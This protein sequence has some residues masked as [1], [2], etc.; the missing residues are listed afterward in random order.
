MIEPLLLSVVIPTHNRRAALQRTLAALA[1]QSL[2]PADFEVVVVADGCCD[3]TEEMVSGL[4]AGICLNVVSQPASGPGAARNAGAAVARG[5]IV[6]FLDDD[7]EASPGL[8]AAHVRAHGRSSDRVVLGYLPPVLETQQGYIRSLLRLWWEN[9]FQTLRDPAHQFKYKNLLTGNVSLHADLFRRVGGFEPRLQ[10]HEDYELGL[11]LIEA[12]ATFVFEP[13][14]RGHHHEL[15]DVHRVLSRKYQEGRADVLL[16][17]LHP[18]LKPRLRL[19]HRTGSR[20][21]GALVRFIFASPRASG[22]FLR[23]LVALLAP[24]EAMGMRRTWY[25]LLNLLMLAYYWRGVAVEIGSRG[26][27]TEFRRQ[28]QQPA[29]TVPLKID[30]AR[31]IAVAEREIQR[32]RPD[33]LLLWFGPH[34][35]GEAR[36]PFG[37]EPFRAPHLH[38]LLARDHTWPLIAALATE[39]GGW[40]SEPEA[41][42]VAPDEPGP[43]TGT[44]APGGDPVNL[45]PLLAAAAIPTPLEIAQGPH[46]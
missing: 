9:M 14:A 15:T 45:G 30:L 42:D 24:L 46:A 27:L 18:A 17:Q 4:N 39:T 41:V 34:F 19:T 37:T 22:A 32:V 8:L 33:H 20:R 40:R 23:L 31:G 2:S 21:R 7:I 16:G 12:R 43:A 1:R 5:R 38:A 28:T 25:S 44:S 36:V 3:G 29:S 6:L 13:D 26:A 11:R 35:V 10:V